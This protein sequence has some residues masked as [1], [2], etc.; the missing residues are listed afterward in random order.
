MQGAL[1]AGAV[2]RV[3]LAGALVHVVDLRRRHLRLAQDDLAV[4]KAR[5]GHTA[6][7]EDDLEQVLAVVRLF[8]SL[9]DIAGQ[10]TE[11]GFEVVGNS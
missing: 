8:H 2:I 10:D 3:E 6:Q 9:A 11:Q 4:H 1:D 5:R 7:I